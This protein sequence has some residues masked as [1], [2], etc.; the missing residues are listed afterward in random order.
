MRWNQPAVP[1]R[2]SVTLV[3]GGG[4]GNCGIR[5]SRSAGRSAAAAGAAGAGESEAE[6]DGTAEACQEA[7]PRAE[8][9]LPAL[10]PA[11][12]GANTA[13][14]NIL[15]VFM[16]AETL[17]PRRMCTLSRSCALPHGR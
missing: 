10:H 8:G 12:T 14:A 15:L 13:A 1:F 4:G 17:A 6:A 3:A 7:L 16:P 9:V 5:A 11:S 2:G